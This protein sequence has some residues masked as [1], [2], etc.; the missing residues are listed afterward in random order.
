MSTHAKAGENYAVPYY[1]AASI[2]IIMRAASQV[3]ISGF[4]KR[5]WGHP[6]P[7][8]QTGGWEYRLR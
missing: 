3:S 7:P 5:S 4:A 8:K 2:Q 6:M 1:H